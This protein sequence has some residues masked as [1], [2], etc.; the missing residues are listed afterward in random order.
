MPEWMHFPLMADGRAILASA[1]DRGP[2][3]VEET[4]FASRVSSLRLRRADERASSRSGAEMGAAAA[5]TLIS[6]LTSH[7]PHTSLKPEPEPAVAGTEEVEEGAEEDADGPGESEDEEAPG[8]AK[9]PAQAR[10]SHPV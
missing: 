9:A 8:R 2:P 3:R 4:T 5:R 6:A 1:L 7:D 10:P